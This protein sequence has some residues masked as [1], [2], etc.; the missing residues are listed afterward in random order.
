M[1][2]D[3]E[4]IKKALYKIEDERYM[5]GKLLE[6]VYDNEYIL[7]T[8]Y[9]EG[10]KRLASET[11]SLVDEIIKKHKDYKIDEIKEAIED[12]AV[13]E[14]GDNC[15]HDSSLS[16]ILENRLIR[17]FLEE[18]IDESDSYLEETYYTIHVLAA[19]M[20]LNAKDGKYKEEILDHINNNISR[21]N[22][23]RA[24][25]KGD[26][27][28]FFAYNPDMYFDLVDHQVIGGRLLNLAMLSTCLTLEEIYKKGKDTMADMGISD[29]DTEDVEK[30]QLDMEIATLASIYA[31]ATNRGI[32][33]DIDYDQYDEE[34]Q[35]N[36]KK[37]V[38]LGIKYLNRISNGKKYLKEL[39]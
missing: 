25:F 1:E 24:L 36:I 29:E 28:L 3:V 8:I 23:L 13:E 6:Y 16:G 21:S 18:D 10:Y 30:A 4:L 5:Q 37:G 20:Y 7:A 33:I 39:E 26:T 38:N 14:F 12:I 17:G 15:Y 34:V 11:D 31:C 27:D 32:P 2:L 19:D 22:A 35:E 9:Y